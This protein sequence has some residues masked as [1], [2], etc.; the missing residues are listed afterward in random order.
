MPWQDLIE[1]Q[2]VVANQCFEACILSKL[3]GVPWACSPG[4][5]PRRYEATVT[6]D[7][8]SEAEATIDE[9]ANLA[10]WVATGTAPA[11]GLVRLRVSPHPADPLFYLLLPIPRSHSRPRARLPPAC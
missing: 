6:N 11:H 5:I 7:D 2:L 4:F 1:Q 3:N 9:A 8:G 10:A